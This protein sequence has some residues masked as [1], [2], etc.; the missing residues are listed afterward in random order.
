MTLKG[1]SIDLNEVLLACP[2]INP[3]SRI[4]SIDTSDQSLETPR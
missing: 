2:G 1:V 3:A 4:W